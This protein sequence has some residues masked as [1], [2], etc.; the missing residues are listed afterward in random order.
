MHQVKYKVCQRLNAYLKA[1]VANGRFRK[2]HS[3][4]DAPLEPVLFDDESAQPAVAGFGNWFVVGHDP[5][6]SKCCGPGA[7]RENSE[8]KQSSKMVL[9][10]TCMAL[11]PV[12][13]GDYIK[14]KISESLTTSLIQLF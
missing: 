10:Q 3:E 7:A 8:E 14:S 5:E 9:P 4:K 13:V 1:Q 11:V 2:G 6:R 12:H